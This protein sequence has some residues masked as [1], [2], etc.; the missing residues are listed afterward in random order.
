MS[1]FQ[2]IKNV[3]FGIFIIFFAFLLLIAPADFYDTIAFIISLMMII[4]GIRLLWFYFRMS[5]HMVGGKSTLYQAI[6]VL[7]VALFTMAVASM[8]SFVILAYLLGIFSFS[9]VVNILRAFEA[10]KN[11]S[12]KWKL[13]FSVGIISVGFA[14]TLAII[15]FVLK[16]PDILVYG[17]SVSLVISAV[18]KITSAFRKTAVVYIQ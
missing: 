10:K 15:G 12:T 1:R 11:G 8:N 17:F 7:D 18:E 5:R 13:K 16:K 4:Y 3:V 2:R 6:I 9:G 14:V